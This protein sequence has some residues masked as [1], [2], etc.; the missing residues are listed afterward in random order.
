MGEIQISHPK[1]GEIRF[2]IANLPSRKSKCLY[3]MR[4]A[5]CEP[6]AYFRSDEDADKFEQIIDIL[7]EL[8]EV[9]VNEYHIS[10]N[11]ET[12]QKTTTTVR[13]GNACF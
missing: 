5:M 8:L 3:K 7:F 2:G 12:I 9:K 6:L 11:K 10:T 13:P 4:G 1:H